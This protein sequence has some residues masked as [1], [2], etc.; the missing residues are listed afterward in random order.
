MG[1]SVVRSDRFASNLEEIIRYVR[2]V[3]CSPQAAQ[4]ILDELKRQLHLVSEHPRWF[5][6]DRRMSDRFG[7]DIY[8]VSVRAYVGYYLVSESSKTVQLITL[9]HQSQDLSTFEDYELYEN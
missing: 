8:R 4:A 5:P 6:I 1:Y 9:R 2:T 7:L 3:L